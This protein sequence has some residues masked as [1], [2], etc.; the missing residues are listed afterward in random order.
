[1]GKQFIQI[2][3]TTLRDGEQMQGIAFTPEEK[4]S[5]AQILLQEVKVDRVEVASAR[6]S[7]GEMEAVKGITKW[8]AA[9]GLLERVEVLGFV[10]QQKSVD[11]LVATGAKA[12]NLLAKGSLLHLTEQLRKSPEQHFNDIRETV[13][14]AKSKGI[15]VNVFLEDW[16]NGIQN[17]REYVLQLATELQ[18]MP[19]QRIFLTDTLGILSPDETFAFAKEMVERFPKAHFEFHG[20]NDYGMAV[21][22]NL[23][24]VK[25][26]CMGVHVTVNGLGERAGNAALEET[27]AVLNDKTDF[28]CNVVEKNLARVSK[29]VETFSGKRIAANKPIVGSNVFTQTAGVHADGDKKARL[30]ESKLRPERFGKERQYALGKLSGKASLEQNLEQLGLKL[31][32]EDK[33][34]VLQRIVELGDMKKIVTTEDLP[35]IVADVLDTP[36]ERMARIKSCTVSSG[37]AQKPNASFTLQINRKEYSE[38]AVGDGGYDAFMNALAKIAEKIKLPLPKLIDYE[39]R[40]PPGGATDALVE[41]TITWLDAENRSFTTIGVDSDQVMAAVKATEKMLNAIARKNSGK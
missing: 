14:Y 1:M 30:Y 15:K 6:A 17:S 19:V 34:R 31:G 32:E 2:M 33:K 39:V 10:D 3:D 13:D 29:I 23:A 18:K 25:A 9:N 12:L 20:H 28:E 16:S 26:G 38:S 22:N 35:Y 8:A 11:W 21:A 7:P 24:A 4:L 27:V 36:E 41:T 5:I 40:I 37:T